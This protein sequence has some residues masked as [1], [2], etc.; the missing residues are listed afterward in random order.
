MGG[1]DSF[2]PGGQPPC[3]SPGA[4]VIFESSALLHFA[5]VV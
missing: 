4:C 3:P 2:D 1:E 5:V